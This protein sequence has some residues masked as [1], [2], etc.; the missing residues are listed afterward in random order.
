MKLL[1][2]YALCAILG[3]LL[4]ITPFHAQAAEHACPDQTAAENG[5]HQ[6]QYLLGKAYDNGLC[7]LDTNKEAAAQWYTRAAQQGH[8]EAAYELGETYF[9]GDGLPI[10]YPLAKKWYLKAGKHGH[11]K[12]Q[13]RLGFLF[14][15]SHFEGLSVD[16]EE[17]ERW[18]IAA[19]AQDAG[20]AKFRLGNFYSYY[21]QPPDHEQAYRWLRDAAMGGHR[22]A[23]YDLARMYK[24]GTGVPQ[25]N[26]KALI[27]MTKAAKADVLQAQMA[28]A[29]MY[30]KGD[31]TP[32]DDILALKWTLTIAKKPTA[33]P[34]WLKKAGDLLFEGR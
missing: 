23:M 11:G 31:G 20:D 25:H 16:M 17:A 7:A 33:S 21:K 4:I 10:N 5:A 22:I 27:W 3:A 29:E 9:T 12:S 1:K 6:Q 19:A 14:A 2:K 26:G 28:L 8:I 18:F 32:Q 13:L 34:F 24:N 30:A 15:E